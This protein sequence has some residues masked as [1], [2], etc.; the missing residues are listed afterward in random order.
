MKVSIIVPCYNSEVYL[1]AC[2]DAILAQTMGDFEAILI[3]DGS[4]DGTPAS[5]GAMHSGMRVSVCCTR[6]TAACPPRATWGWPTHAAS[7]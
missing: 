2:L 3:D 5:P 4:T 6:K 1:G 7:G